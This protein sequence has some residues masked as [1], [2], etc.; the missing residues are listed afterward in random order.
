MNTRPCA[1]LRDD[2]LAR[3]ARLRDELR[4]HRARLL[5][6]AAATGNTFVAGS[7]GAAADAE[8]ELDITLIS[9]WQRELDE[10]S[11]ALQRLNTGSYGHCERCGEPIGLP[12]LRALP[13]AR[14]CRDC[15]EQ[16]DRAVHR[17]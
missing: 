11:A 10:V 14:H 3:E 13:E 7:E 9:H 4:A 17:T 2:L 12:R 15:Q 5:E 1:D 16:A 6:P 8:D